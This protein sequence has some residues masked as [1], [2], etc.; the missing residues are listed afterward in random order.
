MQVLPIVAVCEDDTKTTV[1][2]REL[3]CAPTTSQSPPA[4]TTAEAAIPTD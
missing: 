1:T 2:S 3:Q 4:K